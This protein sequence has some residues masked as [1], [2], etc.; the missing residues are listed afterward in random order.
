[1][2]GIRF[3]SPADAF[4][5]QTGAQARVERLFSTVKL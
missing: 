2:P 3:E 5:S 4:S 1:M